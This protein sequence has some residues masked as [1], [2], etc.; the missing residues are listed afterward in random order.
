VSG[1]KKVVDVL[2]EDDTYIVRRETSD[3]EVLRDVVFDEKVKKIAK[4]TGYPEAVVRRALADRGYLTRKPKIVF[5]KSW[6]IAI[7]DVGI[8]ISI[9]L[10]ILS[11][12]YYLY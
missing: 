1:N 8:Y 3:E 5:G 12:I 11:I 9:L 6:K 10:L 2:M 4:A 7:I